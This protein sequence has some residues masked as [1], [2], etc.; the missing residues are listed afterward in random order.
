MDKNTVIG[1]LLIGILLFGYSIYNKPNK[2]QLE[3]IQKKND[4]IA[5]VEQQR[6]MEEALKKE[7]TVNVNQVISQPSDSSEKANVKREFGL[8]STSAQGKLDFVTL[9]NDLM[10]VKISNRGGRV[11]SVNLKKFRTHDSLPLILF[12]GDSTK[13]GFNFFAQNRNISTN[14]LF[15]VPQTDD[16]EIVA[17]NGN[18]TLALR[19]YAGEN[20][21]I[22]YSY[23]IEPDSYSLLL[24]VN[25]VKMNEII[26]PNSQFLTLNWQ[27]FVPPQEKG[28]QFENQYTS[29]YYKY[30]EDE[31]DNLSSRSDESDESLKTKVKWIAFKQQFFSSVLIARDYFSNAFIKQK[32]L[33]DHNKYLKFFTAEISVPYE[34]KVNQKIPLE[35]YFGPNHFKT[36]Q[37][38]KLDMGRLVDLGWGIFGWINRFAIIPIFDFLS[39]YFVNYGLIIL[40]LTLIIKLVVFPFTFKSYQSQAKMRVLKPQI[41]EIGKKFPKKE[42][43]MKKQQATMALYKKVGVN[44]LGGCLPMVFQMPVLF[45]MFRFFPSSIELRQKSFLWA[46]D[47]SSYD[48]VL[49]LPWDIPFYG[50]H[51]SLFTLLMTISTIIY[52]KMNSQMQDTNSQMPGMK[53]MMYMFPVMMLFWFN[54]YAAGLSYYYFLANIITFGQMY[55]IKRFVDDEAVLKKL[56][57][58]KKKAPKKSGFQKKLEDAAKKRGYNLPKK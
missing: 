2:E 45:A 52:T 18:K 5:M 56:Q 20:R 7:E 13:F 6:K 44:P 48:S 40:L 21:Y 50:D 4:S 14:N 9:E 43:A 51:V 47:L 25:L 34:A 15:F 32:K 3:A 31:V 27:Y 46:T 37:K 39:R 1:L 35:F 38:Y 10:V 16:K 30:Y 23:T 55:F 58:S 28:R 54:N 33:D 36:L 57:M 24:D 12:N 26:A 42:D 22:E 29:I 49:K 11:Y 41:D 8:F 17:K 19:L 53:Y